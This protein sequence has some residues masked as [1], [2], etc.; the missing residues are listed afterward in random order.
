[1]HPTMLK[2]LPEGSGWLLVEFGGDTKEESDARG[3]R[4]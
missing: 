2:L 3:A 4:G 1:M